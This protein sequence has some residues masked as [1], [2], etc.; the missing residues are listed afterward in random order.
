VY[1]DLRKLARARMARVAPGQTLQATALVHDAYLRV[2]RQ[3]DPGWEGR[4]HFFGA[5]AQAMRDI[6]VEQA[7]RKSAVKRGGDRARVAGAED[8]PIAMSVPAED[9][10]ALDEELARLQQRS[11]R[12]ARIVMLRF[13]TGL[14]MEE[15]AS[16]LGISIS[17]VEREWRFARSWLQRR[18]DAGNPADR[19][20]TAC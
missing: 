14:E 17:T 2:T 7:R 16:M 20:D 8:L 1:E 12:Q 18:L 5:A 13:F 4:A 10:L 19:G 11:E 9:V 6:L 3:G 15:I